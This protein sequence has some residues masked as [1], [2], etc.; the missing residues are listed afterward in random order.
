MVNMTDPIVDRTVRQLDGYGLYDYVGRATPVARSRTVSLLLL[1]T[2]EAESTVPTTFLCRQTF[3]IEL[4]RTHFKGDSY[5][6]MPDHHASPLC[7]CPM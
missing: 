3:F 4:Q 5:A 2:C 1:E 6:L 7:V